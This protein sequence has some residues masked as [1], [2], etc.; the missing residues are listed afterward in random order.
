MSYAQS[1]LEIILQHRLEF[2]LFV[3]L[4]LIGLVALWT[5]LRWFSGARQPHPENYILRWHGVIEGLWAQ[6]DDFYA[7]LNTHLHEKVSQPE[8]PFSRVK[9]LRRRLLA[10]RSFGGALLGEKTTYLQTS[11]KHVSYYL[12][13]SPAPIG[14]SVS[15]WAFTS[16]A[17]GETLSEHDTGTLFSL[18]MHKTMQDVLSLLCHHQGVPELSEEELAPIMR[19]FYAVSF[20]GRGAELP[21]ASSSSDGLPD[22]PRVAS[23]STSDIRKPKTSTLAAMPAEEP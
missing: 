17:E 15:S 10:R 18:L 3:G 11:Y 8:S 23:P 5:L 19:P 2:A 14:L 22:M 9:P 4:L 16:R 12:C 1:V 6:P 7:L 20:S 21:S 13:V